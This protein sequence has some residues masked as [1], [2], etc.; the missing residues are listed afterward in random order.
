MVKFIK[1]RKPYSIRIR[2][3]KNHDAFMR[4]LTNMSKGE[5]FELTDEMVEFSGCLRTMIEDYQ[6]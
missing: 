1:Y 3:K 2:S 6:K 4:I 5:D